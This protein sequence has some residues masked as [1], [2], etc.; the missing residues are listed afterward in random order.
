M[1]TIIGSYGETRPYG[2]QTLVYNQYKPNNKIIS[3]KAVRTTNA[4]AASGVTISWESA[5]WDTAGFVASF[6]TTNI[7]IP[8]PGWYSGIA[9][10][11]AASYTAHYGLIEININ[12]SI[13]SADRVSFDTANG[14]MMNALTTIFTMRYCNKGDIITVSW[15]TNNAAIDLNPY[16]EQGCTLAVWRNG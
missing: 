5:L 16:G 1:T 9:Y 15:D 11:C 4:N 13:I 2:N 3:V 7:V 8:M 6:P 14:T 12:G 10:I